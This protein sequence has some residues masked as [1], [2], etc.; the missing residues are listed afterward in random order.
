MLVTNLIYGFVDFVCY[1]VL[2]K[3]IDVKKVGRRGG[4]MLMM[5]ISA[6]GCFGTAFFTFKMMGE[7]QGSPILIPEIQVFSDLNTDPW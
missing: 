5:S 7:E 2:P 3:I 4:T 1:I 6:I